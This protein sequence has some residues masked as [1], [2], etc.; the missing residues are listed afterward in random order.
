MP[1][2]TVVGDGLED[3]AGVEIINNDTVGGIYRR[4]DGIYPTWERVYQW[5][6]DSSINDDQNVMRGITC[7]PDPKGSNNDVI[8]GAK[9]K[10]G[11]IQIIE[12]SNNHNTYTELD[13]TQYCADL[14]FEGD[15]PYNDYALIAYNEFTLD[16]IDDQPVWWV[17]LAIYAPHQLEQ[18][19]NGAYFLLRHQDG[20]YQWNYI[21]DYLNP[22][23]DGES[24]R[25]TRTIRKSPFPQDGNNTYYFGGYDCL[26]DTSHNTAW[27]CKGVLHRLTAEMTEFESQMSKV[28]IYPNPSHRFVKLENIPNQS[29]IQ[30]TDVAGKIIYQTNTHT[31]SSIT[32]P[33]HGFKGGLY[34]INLL[35]NGKEVLLTK[36]LVVH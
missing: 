12:I 20:T 24:L 9:N 16:T 36:K 31:T 30:I 23:P 34:F 4:V 11:E 33:T 21:Y 7:V 28:K 5:A 32:I 27:I 18:F 17:S 15:W 25:A 6:Y 35:N 22:V 26:S 10:G 2:V 3:S 19:H 1:S 14:W 8:I 13:V 29:T